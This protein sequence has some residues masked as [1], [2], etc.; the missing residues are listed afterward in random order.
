MGRSISISQPAPLLERSVSFHGMRRRRIECH[1]CLRSDATP[2][3]LVRTGK[4]RT[5]DVDSLDTIHHA[6]AHWRTSAL[7]NGPRSRTPARALRFG[8]RTPRNS[9]N[10]LK[11]RR[12]VSKAAPQNS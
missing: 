6:F 2:M 9:F 3:Y 7:S 11:T 1:L 4:K 5:P 8:A 10:V 12:G